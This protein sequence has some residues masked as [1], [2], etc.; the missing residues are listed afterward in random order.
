MKSQNKQIL[1]YIQAGNSITPIDAL[2]LF[3]CF[4]LSARI[5]DLRTQGYAIQKR[6]I[7][8]GEKR[9]ASYNLETT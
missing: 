9:F 5:H 2:Q 4:R 7:Q 8:K 3:N 1:N 6:M